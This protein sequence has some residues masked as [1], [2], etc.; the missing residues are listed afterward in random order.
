MS[1]ITDHRI[2]SPEEWIAQRKA[3]LWGGLYLPEDRLRGLIPWR[4]EAKKG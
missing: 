3:V 4:R 1:N 2:V